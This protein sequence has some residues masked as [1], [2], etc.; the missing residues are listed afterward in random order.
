[1]RISAEEIVV[2]I[3]MIESLQQVFYVTRIE[4]RIWNASHDTMRYNKRVCAEYEL[5]RTIW[6]EMRETSQIH[7]KMKKCAVRFDISFARIIFYERE[8]V[9]HHVFFFFDMIFHIRFFTFI[10]DGRFRLRLVGDWPISFFFDGRFKNRSIDARIIFDFSRKRVLDDEC[11]FFESLCRKRSWNFERRNDFVLSPKR[12]MFTVS[13]Y[14]CRSIANIWR[15]FGLIG[16]H[17]SFIHF[18]YTQL[19]LTHERNFRQIILWRSL[20]R[21]CQ[22]RTWR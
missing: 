15:L 22:R 11:D 12:S 6:Y 3:E 17:H 2:I 19:V 20:S 5:S 13:E 14:R 4:L 18:F 7:K 9:L 8:C 16:K 21:R 10:S 1:M